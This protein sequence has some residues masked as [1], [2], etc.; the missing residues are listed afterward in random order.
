MSHVYQLLNAYSGVLVKFFT[1]YPLAAALVTLLGV[2]V[3]LLLQQEWRKGQTKSNFFIV[4]LGWLVLV[5][6]L[7][8]AVT[9]LGKVWAVIEAAVIW[10]GEVLGS[11]GQV[12]QRHPYMVL[13]IVGLGTLYYISWSWWPRWPRVIKSRLLKLLFVL[14]AAIVA[15][16]LAS[17][18]ADL[19]S[20]SGTKTSVQ[21]AGD[22]KKAH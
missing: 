5:P 15:L 22:Q 14:L 13:T 12:Y 1:D 19:I 17:P 18:L 20:P 8:F 21:S 4:L 9:I 16:E 10:F 2:G 3:F 6:I 11:V 7:G